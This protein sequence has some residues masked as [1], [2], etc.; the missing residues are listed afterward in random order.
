MFSPVIRSHGNNIVS[1][2][3]EI[4]ET[5]ILENAIKIIDIIIKNTATES[6]KKRKQC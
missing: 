3:K 6:I 1:A 2:T 4:L 5:H